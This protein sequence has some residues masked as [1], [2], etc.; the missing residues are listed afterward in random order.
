MTIDPAT[1]LKGAKI[2]SDALTVAVRA[3]QAWTEYEQ[4]LLATQLRR[5]AAGEA[6][7]VEDVQEAAAKREARMQ[8]N[9]VALEQAEA[10]RL[11]SLG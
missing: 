6:I 2:L 3:K 5:E 8:A 4:D 9:G 10:A 7:T 11:A 1:V